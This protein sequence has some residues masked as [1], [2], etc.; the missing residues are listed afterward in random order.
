MALNQMK[1][2]NWTAF[3]TSY[4][5]TAD[6]TGNGDTSFT[7]C[8]VLSREG[9]LFS[10]ELIAI[11]PEHP[12]VSLWQE[13][14]LIDSQNFKI[15]TYKTNLD[16]YLFDEKGNNTWKLKDKDGAKSICII[17]NYKIDNKGEINKLDEETPIYLK[18]EV[19]FYTLPPL[20]E[21]C[22]SF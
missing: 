15:F 13:Y 18:E 6:Y 12:D 7:H 8:T 17:T 4:V 11:Q 5:K 20:I 1:F 19:I 22:R 14:V 16:I 3:I 9:K 10:K 2:E 21:V